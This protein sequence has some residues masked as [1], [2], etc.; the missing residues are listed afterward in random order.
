MKVKNGFGANV[1]RDLR[2]E[3][4]EKVFSVLKFNKS[5]K[6]IKIPQEITNFLE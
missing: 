5:K 1:S 6:I 2:N 4:W 3:V